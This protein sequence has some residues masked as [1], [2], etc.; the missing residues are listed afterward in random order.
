MPRFYIHRLN[1]LRYIADNEGSEFADENAARALIVDSANDAINN[2]LICCQSDKNQKILLCVDDEACHQ[3]MSLK[4][5][6]NIAHRAL[7]I[8]NRE[9]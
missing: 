6:L 1:N 9:P 4:I 2:H 8:G 7:S 3:I 5:V